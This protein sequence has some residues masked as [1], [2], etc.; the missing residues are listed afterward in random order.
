VRPKLL[1]HLQQ[2][3]A[4]YV[5]IPWTSITVNQN[6]KCLPHRDK[7]NVGESFLVA[8]GDYQGGDLVI[9]EGDLSG[10][11]PIGYT[12]IQTDFSKVLH[13]VTDF[14]G[15]RYSLVFYTLKTTRMPVEPLPKGE[16]V[17]ENGQYLFKRGGAI[18][19]A[20]EGLPHPKRGQG[21]SQGGAPLIVDR[22][23]EGFT[24]SFP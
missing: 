10:S 5:P 6:F 8:F 4:T 7:G 17:F 22:S 16:V 12:P 24:L 3:A 21:R 11:H 19:T 14:T 20:R 23:K 15:D 18:I 9:H 13:S 2:F 1:Y